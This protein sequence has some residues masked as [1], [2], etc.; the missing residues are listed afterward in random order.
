MIVYTDGRPTKVA[1]QIE[2][3]GKVVA[4]ETVTIPFSTNFEAEYRSI[5]EALKYLSAPKQFRESVLLYN[6]N[7][8]VISQILGKA[9]IF[10]PRLKV[11]YDEVANYVASY[12]HKIQFEWIEKKG[13]KAHNLFER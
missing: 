7:A 12:K 9:R 6:D 1:F 5:I 3:S 2:I 8:T 4:S 10:E 11:L 13:N